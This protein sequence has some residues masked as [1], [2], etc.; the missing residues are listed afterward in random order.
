[1]NLPSPDKHWHSKTGTRF[2]IA[3]SD[4]I[5]RLQTLPIRFN[6]KATLVDELCGPDKDHYRWMVMETN[7]RIEAFHRTVIAA[8]WAF[9]SGVHSESRDTKQWSLFHLAHHVAQDLASLDTIF[10]QLAWT[11]AP[12]SAKAL[13]LRRLGFRLHPDPVYRLVFRDDSLA[14]LMA[15]GR[16]SGSGA[17]RHASA[18]DREAIDDLARSGNGFVNTVEGPKENPR[19][20]NGSLKWY[21]KQSEKT[22]DAALAYWIQ[23]STLVI[24]LAF[25]AGP[26]CDLTDGLASLVLHSPGNGIASVMV[27]FCATCTFTAIRMLTLKPVVFSP[28]GAVRL[29]FKSRPEPTRNE[30]GTDQKAGLKCCRRE[31]TR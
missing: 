6:Y 28:S 16:T 10:G 9:W 14:T 21:V 23:G 18:A 31:E 4:D 15:I 17:W 27:T 24:P 22:L 7:G 8:G 19:P 29:F 5:K 2:R 26:S 13:F 30:F 11:N 12:G 25:A 3:T 20:R 1:M